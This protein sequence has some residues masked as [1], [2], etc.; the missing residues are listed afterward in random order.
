MRKWM[1]IVTW[2][3]DYQRSWLRN[4]LMSGATVWAVLVPTGLAYAGLVGV[5]PVVGLYT[6]PFALIAYAIFGGSRILVVG[7]DAA[8]SVL[9]G[10]T[11]SMPR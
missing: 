4:D 1:P 5:E 7:P 11:M 6:I 9:A 10:A 2:L 3:P 8:V